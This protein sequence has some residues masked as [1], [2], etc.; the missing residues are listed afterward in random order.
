VLDLARA[1]VLLAWSPSEVIYTD[2]R[3]TIR[4]SAARNLASEVPARVGPG[5]SRLPDGL[6]RTLEW[7][8]ETWRA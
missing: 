6:P 3:S 7:A 5:G 2:R 8:R 4:R 1:I